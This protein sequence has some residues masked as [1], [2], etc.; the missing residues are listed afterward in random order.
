M[1]QYEGRYEEP[2]TY[3][4]LKQLIDPS[5]YDEQENF[6]ISSGDATWFICATCVSV[7]EY[8]RKSLVVNQDYVLDSDEDR[9]F[10][11]F[12]GF[13]KTA[14]HFNTCSGAKYVLQAFKEQE[15]HE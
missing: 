1:Q 5:L 15:N 12:I 2:V 7:V 14:E 10:L 9:V 8:V 13:K 4:E 3:L 6:P 11:S